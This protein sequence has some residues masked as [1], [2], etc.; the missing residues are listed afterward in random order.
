M[1]RPLAH[2]ALL[3]CLAACSSPLPQ[4]AGPARD[5]AARAHA[6]AAV[7][8]DEEFSGTLDGRLWYRCYP[9]VSGRKPGCTNGGNLELE[10]YEPQNVAVANGIANLT[11]VVK[12]AHGHPYTSGMISTGGQ[13]TGTARFAFL[14]GYAE[15]RMKLPRG[16]GMWPAFWLVPADRTWPPEIDIM[17]YQGVQ[18]SIDYATVHWGSAKHQQQD[19]SAVDTG[20]DLSAAFHTY[21]VLWQPDRIVWY[22]DGRAIKRFARAAGIPHKPMYVILNL[23]IGGWVDGQLTPQPDE[24]PATFA[25]DYVRV[26]DRKP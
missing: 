7:L 3:A 24:F 10:W 13:S 18:P 2:L 21:A 19:G 4:T 23:A 8:L 5:G 17:E 22:F 16:A 9:W 11:A 15:A 25:I 12:R 1:T 6:R 20:V 14:Y 26:W